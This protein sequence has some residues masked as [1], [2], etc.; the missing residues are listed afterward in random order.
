MAI[1]E[2]GTFS[3]DDSGITRRDWLRIS[4]WGGICIVTAQTLAATVAS[5]WPKTQAGGFGSV[6]TAGM[7]D[8]YQVGS[9]T[10]FPKGHF[11]LSRVDS[12]FLALS[13][14]CT[15]LGCVVPFQ[16]DQP[17]LDKL[18]PLGRFN[19][20]CHGGMYDRYGQ[21]IT[22][23]PP[24]PLDLYPIKIEQGKILVDTGKTITRDAY[25]ASQ[26]VGVK[27]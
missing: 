1:N 15:H 3:R 24:R 25:R 18:A 22:G 2:E 7:V 26:T 12:G 11:Y 23:P 21:V 27:A 9:V 13:W 19:C 17:S 10:V 8:D 4:I 6:I 5:L 14:K 20:P 16:T